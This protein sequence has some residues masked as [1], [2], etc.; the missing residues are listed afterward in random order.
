LDPTDPELLKEITVVFNS[1]L[2]LYVLF[3]LLFLI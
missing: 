3:L 1:N 2:H